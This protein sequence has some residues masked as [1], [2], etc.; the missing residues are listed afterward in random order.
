MD[1]KPADFFINVV[2]FFAVLLP[3]ALFMAVYSDRLRQSAVGVVSPALLTGAGGVAS[4]V[5]GSYL[6]GHIFFLIGSLA[7]YAYNAL[8][9]RVVTEAKNQAFKVADDLRKQLTGVTASA[10]NTYQ[11]CITY[12]RVRKPSYLEP[13]ER[14]EA[15]SKFFRTLVPVFLA[16][17]WPIC[18]AGHGRLA[19]F[20]IILAVLSVWRYAERRWKANRLAFW[21]VIEDARGQRSAERTAT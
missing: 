10:F 14:L 4:F 7:D 21:L 17:L 3:G 19:C 8:L 18:N 5:V 1:Y 6:F 13:I 9:P 16:S 20:V 2:D 15:D 11:W 12:L